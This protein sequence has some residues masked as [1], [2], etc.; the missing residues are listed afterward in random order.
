MEEER[1]QERHRT[2]ADAED[3]PAYD[4]GEESLDLEQLQ[5]EDRVVVVQ[6]MSDI[7]REQ[8]EAEDD[9]E[10]NRPIRRHAAPDQREAGDESEQPEPRENE[11]FVVESRDHLFAQIGD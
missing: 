8:Q 4:P 5:V 7:G 9:Q 10:R 6:R 3:E 2:N 11:A 1:Q